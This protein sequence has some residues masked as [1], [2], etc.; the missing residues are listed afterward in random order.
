MKVTRRNFLK[1]NLLLAGYVAGSPLLSFAR[2]GE[3]RTIPVLAYHDI[4]HQ[5]DSQS[6]TVGP[7]LFAAQMEWLYAEGWHSLSLKEFTEWL[8][9]IKEIPDRSFLITFDDGYASILDVVFPLFDYY[10]FKGVIHIIGGYAG[11]FYPLNGNRPMLSWDEYRFLKE[12]GLFDFGCH[13]NHLHHFRDGRSG[14]LAASGKELME[15]LLSFKE[16]IREELGYDHSVL[17]WPYG[18]YNEKTVEIALK[19]GY[20]YLFTSDYGFTGRSSDKTALPRLMVSEK[21]DLVSFQQYI[22]GD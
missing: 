17:A 21:I 19:A 10:R 14:V 4:S 1:I 20:H 22:R 15:D 2:A 8:S 16:K 9:G 12:S 18:Q 3:E 5:K 13:S 6:L 11:T 7:D